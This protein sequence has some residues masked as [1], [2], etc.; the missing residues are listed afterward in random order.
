MRNINPLHY[1]GNVITAE[2]EMGG[3]GS[4]TVEAKKKRV[5]DAIILFMVL[6]DFFTAKA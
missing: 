3:E 4:W 6:G 1:T 5:I 2:D